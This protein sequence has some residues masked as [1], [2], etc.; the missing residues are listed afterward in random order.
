[1]SEEFT[2]VVLNDNAH[3]GWFC[4]RRIYIIQPFFHAENTHP[5]FL[6]HLCSC[7]K[8]NS[9]MYQLY[10]HYWRCCETAL[11]VRI[12]MHLTHSGVSGVGGRGRTCGGHAS[13]TW[14]LSGCNLTVSHFVWCSH[15]H[16]WRGVNVSLP[17]CHHIL[18]SA[19]VRVYVIC[20]FHSTETLSGFIVMK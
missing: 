13:I 1:M 9:S 12:Y 11:N 10:R 20:G 7:R 3:S 16:G 17:P 5:A 8:R 6:S 18:H 4:Q 19:F 15:T 14:L 2:A